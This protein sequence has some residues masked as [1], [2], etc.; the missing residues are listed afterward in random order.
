MG[1]LVECN[2][3]IP[4]TGIENSSGHNTSEFRHELLMLVLHP[5]IK[6]FA[7]SLHFLVFFA[8]I[9]QNHGQ[10]DESDLPNVV[11]TIFGQT[12]QDLDC[13]LE[14]GTSTRNPNCHRHP[15]AGMWVV[16]IGEQPHQVNAILGLLEGQE[17]KEC[18]RVT[19]HLIGHIGDCHVHQPLD[20]LGVCCSSIR[21]PNH[22]YPPTPEDGIL[23]AAQDLNQGIRLIFPVVHDQR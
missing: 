20:R 9:Y 18:N 14:V 10:A 7:E 8:L 3:N 16:R 5:F 17:S 6:R 12:F 19:P 4:A 1:V 22:E 15:I 21:H 11:N 13:I 23:V 2:G